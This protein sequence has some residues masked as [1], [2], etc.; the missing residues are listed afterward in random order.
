[1]RVAII[2]AGMAGLT[3]AQNLK[4]FGVDV[5]LFDKGRGPG[6]RMST[7]RAEL[8]GSMVRFDH[9]AQ[10]ISPKSEAFEA[11]VKRWIKA[12]VAAE[13]SG[14]LVT[15]RSDGSVEERESKLAYVG[16]PGMNDIIRFLARDQTVEWGKRVSKVSHEA[17]WC[18]HFEDGNALGNFDHVVIAVP[19][20][21][22]ADILDGLAPEISKAAQIT[23]S[24][25]CWTVMASFPDRLNV[26]WDGAVIEDGPISWAARNSS[27][28]GR[29]EIETWVL[30]ASAKWSAEHLEDE[31]ESVSKKI[32]DAFK[33]FCGVGKLDLCMAHRWRYS[34]IKPRQTPSFYFDR[35]LSISACGD[36]CSGPKI[37]DAWSSGKELAK[38]ILSSK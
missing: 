10:Y 33:V 32:L 31:K 30:Q 37:E 23:E 11:E 5:F 35:D 16:T 24:D 3:A 18:L 38:V 27:K 13:W 20:E 8:D 12:G 17:K 25:P 4:R 34:Q 29:G 21:Q 19:A 2:G 36:W 26:D 15:I 7:R 1:M 6:G 9:G 22:V 28:P 14:R